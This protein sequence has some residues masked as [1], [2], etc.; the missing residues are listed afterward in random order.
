[1]NSPDDSPVAVKNS[2]TSTPRLIFQLT[3][4][5][6]LP[7]WN[8]ILGMEQW[9]RY[10]F[11]KELAAVFLSELQRS[12]NGSSTLTTVAK[13]ITS[14]FSAT[15]LAA[16]LAMIQAKR[17]SK[18]AKSKLAKASR[19]KCASTSLNCEKNPF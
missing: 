7:S 5:G 16:H 8:A 4:P 10:Q 13:N 3:V 11:K 15:H 17:K 19:K 9:Q 14:I 12:E 6:R 2:S 18:L 1:M